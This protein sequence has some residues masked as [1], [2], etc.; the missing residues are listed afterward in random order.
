MPQLME[1]EVDEVPVTMDEEVG[2]V[3][4]MSQADEQDQATLKA[5][6]HL[7]FQVKME[8]HQTRVIQTMFPVLL[9][10]LLIER[11]EVVMALSSYDGQR[12]V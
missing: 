2:V 1:P 7:I 10:H 4:I 3:A 8:S 9:N 11:Q 5:E 12:A 6:A